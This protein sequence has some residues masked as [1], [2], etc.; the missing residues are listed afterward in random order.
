MGF[1]PSR[2]AGVT[3]LRLDGVSKRYGACVSV[4]PSSVVFEAGVVHA[5]IGENGAGK[6]TLL[7]MAAGIVVPDTGHVAIDD[8]RLSPHTAAQA[9]ARGV[10]MVAQHFAL[11]PVFTALENIELGAEIVVPGSR[12]PLARLDPAAARAK[13]TV[14]AKELGVTLPLDTKVARLSLGDRQRV[15]IVRALFRDAKVVILDEP[16]AVL[17]PGEADGLYAM[18][19]RLAAAGRAIVVVTHKLDEVQRFADRVTVMRKGEVLF[20]RPLDRSVARDV[21][22]RALAEA[23]MGTSLRDRPEAAAAV[24]GETCLDLR[25][26]RVD[27]VLDGVS[28]AVR[29]GEIVGLAGVEGNGQ[30]ELAMVLAGLR[31]PDSGVVTVDGAPLPPPGAHAP[32]SVAVVHGDRHAEGL[33]LDASVAENL[34]LGELATFAS[35]PLGLVNRAAVVSE[36]KA[37]MNRADIVPRDSA[38]AARALSGGNQQKIVVARAVAAARKTG[39][40]RALVVAHPTRG[41][42]IRSARAIHDE[43]QALGARG[44]AVLVVSSDLHELREIC[45]RILVIA[46]GR[47]VAELPP[48]APD[49]A[50]G[51][52]MLAGG[53]AAPHR[54]P[55]AGGTEVAL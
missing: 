13:A 15:E 49:E 12:G 55:T 2:T 43:I 17:T 47:I 48:D 14:V 28:L 21:E 45:H 44:L 39:G 53:A 11:I 1:C 7:K 30:Q 54:E 25:D 22:E 36:V 8:A 51:R 3:T 41:V 20:T 35:G 6:S 50:F 31:A 52:A 40:A 19:R 38:T 9:I 29:H 24:L 46:R 33:V 37:R 34:V 27:R 10:A 23:I 4:R 32:R 5:V 26:L 16:T 42:D 18:L